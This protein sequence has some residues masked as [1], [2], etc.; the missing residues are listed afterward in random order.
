MTEYGGANPKFGL[1]LLGTNV[2]I[3]ND[4]Q[5]YTPSNKRTVALGD[6]VL[7]NCRVDMAVTTYAVLGPIVFSN[8][9]RITTDATR[10]FVCLFN[11]HVVKDA[12]IKANVGLR[13]HMDNTASNKLIFTVQ[14]GIYPSALNLTITSMH[15][16]V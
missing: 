4:T 6:Y 3:T 12:S 14:G 10:T 1:E 5:Y 9:V 16:L 2:F 8:M 15:K 11:V 7:F 13:V